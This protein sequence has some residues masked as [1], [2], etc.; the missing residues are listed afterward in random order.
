V[1]GHRTA[2]RRSVA[3]HAAIARRLAADPAVLERARARVASWAATGAVHPRWVEG[4]RAVLAGDAAA[5]AAALVD[6][7]EG[8]T[9][10]RQVS[11]FAGALPP[12]ERWQIWRATS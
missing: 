8:M 10:L 3:Y 6:P 1:D 7:G 2:E 11:P 5:I 12:R 9:A 4:W